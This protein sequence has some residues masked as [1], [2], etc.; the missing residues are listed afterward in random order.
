MGTSISSTEDS[1]PLALAEAS[2]LILRIG[3]DTC[4]DF[5][6][7]LFQ[8]DYMTGLGIQNYTI[9]GGDYQ[10]GDVEGGGYPYTSNG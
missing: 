9:F 3:L 5:T 4:D 10:L 2:S 6:N 1:R 7:S 8:K